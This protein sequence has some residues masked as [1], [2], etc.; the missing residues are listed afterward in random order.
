[1][2]D[3]IFK[4]RA[5]ELLTIGAGGFCG[6][7]SRY[8]IAGL[9]EP[10]PGTLVVNVLGSILLGFLMYSSEYLGYVSPRM[11]MFFG[12]GFLGSLTT[13]STFTVQTFQMPLIEAGFNIFANLTLTL[14][15]V[16]TGRSIVIYLVKRREG[17][18]I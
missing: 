14:A 9:F 18:G 12:I 16:F 11:R 17:N 4:D 7:I 2:N 5:L 15:G 8:L 6:A 1:M 10:A 13:F 3:H